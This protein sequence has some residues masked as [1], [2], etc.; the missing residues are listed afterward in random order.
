MRERA[1]RA[2]VLPALAEVFREHGFA[3]AS[4][5]LITEATGLGKGSLYNFFPGGKEEMLA[6]VLAE[7]DLWFETH[8]FKPLRE[9]KDPQHAIDHM[10]QAVDAYFRS[11]RRLCLVGVV[12]VGDA[13]DV[14]GER[15][16]RYFRAWT[17]ALAAALVR[18]GR[19]GTTASALA[20]EAVATIQGTLV[21]AR[22][23]PESGA[24]PRALARLKARLLPA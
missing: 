18:A 15:V 22:A 21:L 6:A 7:V 12:A 14:F 19:D 13:R 9:E 23:L 20:E 3:G 2:A 11:G 24:F 1:D 8:V 16:S 17:E 5:S 4:L 10:L